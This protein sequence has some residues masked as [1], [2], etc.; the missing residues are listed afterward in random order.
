VNKPEATVAFPRNGT[1]L[2]VIKRAE[3]LRLILRGER[4][5]QAQIARRLRLGRPTVSAVVADLKA[6]GL[7]AETT[8]G[9]STK[10]GGKPP[11][12][13]GVNEKQAH[14][15]AVWI[16]GVRIKSSLLDLT[17]NVIAAGEVRIAQNHTPDQIAATVSREALA[18]RR[19]LQR[20]RPGADLLG[21]GIALS[22]VA[23]PRDG[24]VR[25]SRNYNM[26]DFPLGRR[27]QDRVKVPVYVADYPIV[28]AFHEYWF[29]AAAGR[30][31]FIL[32]RMLPFLRAVVFINGEI[33]LGADF[34][35]GEIGGSLSKMGFGEPEYLCDRIDHDLFGTPEISTKLAAAESTAPRTKPALDLE[36]IEAFIGRIEQDK[37][38]GKMTKLAHLAGQIVL[39]LMLYYNPE[40]IILDGIPTKWQEAFM[41]NASGALDRLHALGFMAGCRFAFTERNPDYQSRAV[42]SMVF[43]RLLSWD[44]KGNEQGQRLP[45]RGLMNQEAV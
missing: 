18:M 2:R 22:G 39:N 38:N 40:L 45:K 28:C 35:A 14:V 33:Y 29:G 44:G 8:V 42:M 20:L 1:A 11:S 3:V 15:L 19:N 25:L 17:G 21:V 23:D 16:E 9:R 37:L 31:N 30:R 43:E 32:L 10:R 41:K 7:V 4:I 26:R 5:S 36:S 34:I 6:R 13:L 27:V 12:M 24:T